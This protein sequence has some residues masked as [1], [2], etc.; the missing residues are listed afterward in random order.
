MNAGDKPMLSIAC[1]ARL[2]SRGVGCSVATGT[3]WRWVYS[4]R[5]MAVRVGWR[6]MIPFSVFEDSVN[7]CAFGT[8]I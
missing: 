2:L 4:G 5:I 7:K 6:W 3:V 1:F 8:R